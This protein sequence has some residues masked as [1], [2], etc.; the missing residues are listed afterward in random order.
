[1]QKIN[2][3]LESKENNLNKE[4]EIKKDISS[5][6]CNKDKK[7]TYTIIITIFSLLIISVIIFL[8]LFFKIKNTKPIKE[9]YQ[10]NDII[11]L[12]GYFSYKNNSNNSFCY[13]CSI[14]NCKKCEGDI[15]NNSCLT[16]IDNYV[17]K[18]ENNT[19]ISCDLEDINILNGNNF[20]MSD[21]KN[22]INENISNNSFDEKIMVNLKRINKKGRKLRISSS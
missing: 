14:E 20:I 3:A 7:I 22:E 6:K 8:I 15:N 4:K 2:L 18:Y 13:S 16:C 10:S 1:M 17:P 21:A 12:D 19:I 11:C 5:Q 9:T